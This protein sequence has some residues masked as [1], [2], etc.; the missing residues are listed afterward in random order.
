ML[1]RKLIWSVC[2]LHTNELPMRALMEN[3]IGPTES[4]TGFSGTIGKALNKV[5]EMATNYQFIPITIGEDLL[6]LPNDVVDD[7]STDQMHAYK[8][9][10]AIRSGNISADLA[11]LKCGPINHSRWLSTANRTVKL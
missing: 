8:L 6:V 1:G 5:D 4:S 7:M 3:L 10:Q 2:N 9:C 11:G